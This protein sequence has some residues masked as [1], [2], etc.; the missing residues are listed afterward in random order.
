MYQAIPGAS[1]CHRELN[2][3]CVWEAGEQ[4]TQIAL[5]AQPQCIYTLTA[6]G[7]LRQDLSHP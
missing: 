6:L 7:M 2:A 5:C 1:L 3:W 4:V